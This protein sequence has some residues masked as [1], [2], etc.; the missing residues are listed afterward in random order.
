MMTV[1]D[2]SSAP[3]I[4]KTQANNGDAEKKARHICSFPG[5]DLRGRGFQLWGCFAGAADLGALK[6][7]TTL[8]SGAYWISL[9][10]VT[11]AFSCMLDCSLI[12]PMKRC[13][14]PFCLTRQVVASCGS[15]L[16]IGVVGGAQVISYLLII[17]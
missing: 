16:G 7:I 9:L 14:R 15:D 13:V 10:C 2:R 11:L 12:H 5:V 6:A 1:L 4:R 8:L 3:W 17:V